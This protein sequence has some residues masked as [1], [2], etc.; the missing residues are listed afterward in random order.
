LAVLTFIHRFSLIPIMGV[1]FCSYLLVAIPAMSWLW[2]LGWMGVG[3][4][5]YFLYGYRNS[6]LKVPLHNEIPGR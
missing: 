3:L 4:V 6:R 1:L 5:I 2:F